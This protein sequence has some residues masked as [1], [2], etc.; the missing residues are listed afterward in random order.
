LSCHDNGMINMW[1][2]DQQKAEFTIPKSPATVNDMIVDMEKG[3]II[4]IGNDKSVIVRKLINGDVVYN[5]K[6]K[7]GNIMKNIAKIT[8]CNC[9]PSWLVMIAEG[10][11]KLYQ[12]S[13]DLNDS[14]YS[15]SLDVM[16]FFPQ[17]KQARNDKIYTILQHPLHPDVI[18]LGTNFGLL[19]IKMDANRRPAVAV[20]LTKEITTDPNL[21]V[22]APP[23]LTLP[24]LNYNTPQSP[25]HF[26]KN[27]RVIY[28]VK[29]QAIF[30]RV[31]ITSA[32]KEVYSEPTK[33]MTLPR[34][35]NVQ[36]G[37]SYSGQYLSILW[38]REQDYEIF[39]TVT[40]KRQASGN[41]T[42]AFVWSSASD[43]RFAVL[44]GPTNAKTIAIYCIHN[45]A[46]HLVNDHAVVSFSIRNIFGG[47]FLG[48]LY[49]DPTD[50]H[51]FHFITWTG[52]E[53]KGGYLPKPRMVEWDQLTSKCVMVYDDSYSV[54][55]FYPDFRMECYVKEKVET[56]RWWNG[57]LFIATE[58]E[59]KCLFPVK[60]Q[61]YSVELASFDIAHYANV[62]RGHED[63]LDPIPQP[64]PKGSLSFI[65]VVGDVLYVIDTNS[66]LHTISLD[67]PT[68]KFRFLVSSRLVDRAMSW[69]PYIPQELHDYCADF[70]VAHAH[71]Y[72]ASQIDT[73]TPSKRFQLCVEYLIVDDGFNALSQID[74]ENPF[75]N[76]TKEE[77]A[78]LYIRLASIGEQQ[79]D[80]LLKS[81]E[82]SPEQHKYMDDLIEILEKSYK[83]ATEL[84]TSLFVQLII[85]YTKHGE[86]DKLR[87]LKQVILEKRDSMNSQVSTVNIDW[88]NVLSMIGLF[89]ND[90][91]FMTDHLRTKLDH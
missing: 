62:S 61:L 18:F 22:S 54:F 27:R 66:V 8:I 25:E 64:R 63:S 80:Y 28:Y 9:I 58:S 2:V 16:K 19:S 49:E 38:E 68:L 3:H 74:S 60:K 41:T 30:Q 50:E 75:Q 73:M 15:N 70:L 79:I 90:F 51:G 52:Q 72:H 86:T 78:K 6:L 53:V 69:I 83:R 85:F 40:W 21:S 57:T 32:N 65:D 71:P 43:D 12:I 55:S 87:D 45:N 88:N 17:K 82:L 13:A 36:L 35:G 1:N 84:D 59:I 77:L 44:R 91:D 42:H 76:L 11:R 89:T 48:V 26:E 29:N 31:V 34:I 20:G 7:A 14:T 23:T 4:T 37:L 47:N 33:V 39:N 46:T 5:S 10:N 56:V 24:N 81:G 67:T